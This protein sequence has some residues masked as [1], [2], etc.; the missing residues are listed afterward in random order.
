M[1]RNATLLMTIGICASRRPATTGARL[2]AGLGAALWQ[3][4][5]VILGSGPAQHREP[6]NWADD[7]MGY[8][9]KCGEEGKGRS[10]WPGML[11]PALQPAQHPCNAPVLGHGLKGPSQGCHPFIAR[12]VDRHQGGS[13]RPVCKGP[14]SRPPFEQE[15]RDTAAVSPLRPGGGHR[16]LPPSPKL[17]GGSVEHQLRDRHRS[18]AQPRE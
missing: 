12:K 5:I 6:R 18:D 11:T 4:P 7:A 9:G 13:N 16:R 2:S 10:P 17:K 1:L 3:P 14:A 15:C 8:A